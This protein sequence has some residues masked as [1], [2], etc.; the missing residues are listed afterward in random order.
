MANWSILYGND[1]V[2]ISDRNPYDLVSISGIGTAPLRQ[3][4]ER[5]PFQD[6]SSS[7][8][9]RL[10]PRIINMVLFMNS[11]SKAGADNQ[12]DI[13]YE[14]FKGLPLP[15]KLKCVKDNG[16]TR[17]IDCYTSG[18]VD[19]P[20]DDQNRVGASQRFAIQLKALNPIWYDPTPLAWGILG[21]SSTGAS[22]FSIPMDIPFVQT[23]NTFI[24]ATLSLSYSGSWYE[25]PVITIFGPGM[26]FKITNNTTGDILN[27]PSLVLAS[28]EYVEV[29]LRYGAKSV[30]DDTGTNVISELSDDSDLVTWRLAPAPIASSG[31]NSISFSVTSDAT[32]ETG[33]RI[34]YYNRYTAL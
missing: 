1:E 26:N 34:N 15:L 32:E 3:L 30:V 8:G 21:G 10:D 20:F 27:F 31:A 19:A 33:I 16:S 25:Y 11:T 29:D 17:L 28:G 6:G 7:V 13:L 14:Y 2:N 24:D 5:S 4:E 18:M 9:F 22:G 23:P 12:R